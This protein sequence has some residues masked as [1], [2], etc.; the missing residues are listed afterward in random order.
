MLHAIIYKMLGA[1]IV[2]YSYFYFALRTK[3]FN[4][5][6]RKPINKK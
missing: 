3:N 4:E 5:K 6:E 1:C 2:F